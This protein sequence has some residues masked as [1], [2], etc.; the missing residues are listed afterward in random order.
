MYRGLF[1]L[2]GLFALLLG[3][4]LLL[5]PRAYLSLYVPVYDPINMPFAA[6]RL[7]P[8]IGGLGALLLL[9][10][11][12]PPSLFASRFAA[13]TAVVWFGVAATGVFHYVSGTAT[14]AILVAALT[15]VI[16]GALFLVVS[17]S[18]RAP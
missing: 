15:E 12:L 7:S 14:F 17:R 9:A 4:I 2:V 8:A 18:H 10:S 16:L 3:A 1:T 13:L 11:T 5:A 6:Q